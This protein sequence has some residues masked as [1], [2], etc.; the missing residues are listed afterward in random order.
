[1]WDPINT[2]FGEVIVVWLRH[3]ATERSDRIVSASCMVIAKV[4][5]ILAS[6]GS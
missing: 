3:G 2:K 6:L 5:S 4:G 1:M